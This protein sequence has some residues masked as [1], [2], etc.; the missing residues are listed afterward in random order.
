MLRFLWESI[1]CQTLLIFLVVF[2][3][4]AD[5]MKH[6]KPKDFPPHPLYLPIVGQMYLM[7]FSNPLMTVQKVRGWGHYVKG[8][9]GAVTLPPLQHGLGFNPNPMAQE[10]SQELTLKQAGRL[11]SAGSTVEEI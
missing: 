3:L 7:N 1:S 9:E 10:D 6:R 8:M 2:L 11:P 5:Y 4:V